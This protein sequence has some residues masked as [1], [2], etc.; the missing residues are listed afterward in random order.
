M[1]A[2]D[3]PSLAVPLDRLGLGL[4]GG[5]SGSEPRTLCPGPHLL[6]MALCD[7]GPPAVYGLSTPDQ[8]AGQGPS[9]PLGQLVEINSNTSHIIFNLPEVL[10]ALLGQQIAST[11]QKQLFNSLQWKH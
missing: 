1:P 2:V 10:L 6:F 8:G 9:W 5:G 7:G 11:W 4:W 3:F